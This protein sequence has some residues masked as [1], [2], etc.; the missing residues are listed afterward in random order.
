[1][2]YKMFFYCLLSL[3]DDSIPELE[4]ENLNSSPQIIF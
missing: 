2:I 4:L 3:K 1:M